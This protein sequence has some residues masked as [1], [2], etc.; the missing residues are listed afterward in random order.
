MEKETWEIT[1]LLENWLVITGRWCFKL[2]KGRDGQILK[3][4]ARWVAHFVKQQEGIDF[5]ET[6]A[7]V[8]KPMSYKCLFGVGVKH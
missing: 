4:K 2:K 3:Y 8:I 5:A 6:F 7:T 1:P